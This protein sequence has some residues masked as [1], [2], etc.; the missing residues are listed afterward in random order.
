MCRQD[1][2]F[3]PSAKVLPPVAVCRPLSVFRRGG[4]GSGGGFAVAVSGGGDI[5]AVVVLVA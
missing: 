1:G 2:V 5:V 4:G 3:A